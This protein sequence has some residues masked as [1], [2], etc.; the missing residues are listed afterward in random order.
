M[1][2]VL[3]TSEDRRA[4]EPTVSEG[5]PGP[6]TSSRA[7]KEAKWTVGD[8]GSAPCSAQGALAQKV[9]CVEACL[10][11]DT[12]SGLR[13]R[14]EVRGWGHTVPPQRIKACLLASCQPKSCCP[15]CWF[16]ALVCAVSLSPC[17]P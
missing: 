17:L 8:A 16:S 4:S 7:Q 15:L 5:A 11:G 13:P 14:A 2:A 10:G 1:V 6:A 3:G 12:G 9:P